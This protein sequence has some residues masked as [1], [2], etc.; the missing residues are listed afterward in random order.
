MSSW[1]VKQ[2]EKKRRMTFKK[3]ELL[4]YTAAEDCNLYL[5][6]YTIVVSLTFEIDSFHSNAQRI[7]VSTL[8]NINVTQQTHVSERSLFIANYI[9]N[10]PEET[11]CC[12]G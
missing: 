8:Q 4:I 6:T 1:W 10:W 9:V 3:S 7:M 2:A 5:I 12:I 11:G